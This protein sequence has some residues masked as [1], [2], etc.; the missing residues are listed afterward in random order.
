MA[1]ALVTDML[2]PESGRRAQTYELR[3]Q[4]GKAHEFTGSRILR[5]WEF[6]AAARYRCKAHDT[7]HADARWTHCGAIRVGIT[8]S[9]SN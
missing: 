2:L 3:E 6:N 7:Q 4:V 8:T 5:L 9:P 1:P